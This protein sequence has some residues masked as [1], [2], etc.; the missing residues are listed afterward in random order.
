MWEICKQVYFSRSIDSQS[1]KVASCTD[2]CYLNLWV[3][4]VKIKGFNK[5]LRQLRYVL[6]L[7]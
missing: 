2:Y 7:C 3:K 1:T 4:D 6:H 5:L